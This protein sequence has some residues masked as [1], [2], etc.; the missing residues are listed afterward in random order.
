[1]ARVLPFVGTRYNPNAVEDVA[2]VMAPPYDVITPEQQNAL[3]AASPYNVVR[4]ILGKET[5]GDD[6]Y[7]N[8]YHRAASF[9]QEWKREGVLINDPGK[10]L[11]VY[12]QEFTGSNGKRLVRTGVFAAVKVEDPAKGKIHAHEHTF[13]G[14]KADRLKLLRST[15]CNLSAVFCLY[16]DPEHRTDAM[17]K[18][19]M[20][21]ESPRIEITDDDGVVHR[22]WV[23]SEREEIRGISDLL[24][25][26]ELFI[27]DGHHRYETAVRYFQ[28]MNHSGDCRKGDHPSYAYTLAYLSNWDSEGV[29]ILPTHRVLSSDLEEGVDHEEVIEDLKQYFTVKP[30]KVDLKKMTPADVRNVTDTLE[31]MGKER[32]AIAMVLPGGKGYYLHLRPDADILSEMSSDIAEPVGRLDVSILHNYIIPTAWIGNPEMELDDQDVFYVKDAMVAL[33]KLK[34]PVN[35]SAVFLMNAPTKEQSL[36]IA[37]ANLRMPHKSTYFYPKLISGMVIRDHSA[38]W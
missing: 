13:E 21:K 8:K 30:F 15:R 29:E 16:S 26:K 32:T 5:P 20:E 10:S 7:N 38:P 22:L 11:Y 34:S 27:A 33:G 3:Y 37:S 2:K 36:D 25:D 14:P 19:S 31:Q 9:F 35:A 23:V 18:K 17:Y 12:Q 1:M 4:L 28:E 6:E 24:Q